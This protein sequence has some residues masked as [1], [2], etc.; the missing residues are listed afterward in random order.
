MTRVIE[1][2]LSQAANAAADHDG[3]VPTD[4]AMKLATEGYDLSAL[5]AEVE[6]RLTD[7]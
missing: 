1:S 7:A 3:V 5:D 6:R 4:I 2:L